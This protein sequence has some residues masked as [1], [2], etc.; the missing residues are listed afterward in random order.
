[1][2]YLSIY[3][4]QN[5]LYESNWTFRWLHVIITKSEEM[6]MHGLWIIENE[7]VRSA[8][9]LLNLRLKMEKKNDSSMKSSARM[10]P[11]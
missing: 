9:K 6:N 7:S 10:Q 4:N 8:S 2:P 3:L 11:T 5:Q 1:M